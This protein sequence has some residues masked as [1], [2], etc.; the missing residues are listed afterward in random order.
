MQ[1]G[2][3]EEAIDQ[4]QRALQ[5]RPGYTHAQENLVKAQAMGRQTSANLI[6]KN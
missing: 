1:K 5:L 4:F 6:N 2:R 3:F